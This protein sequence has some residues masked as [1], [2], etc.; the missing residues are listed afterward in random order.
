MNT[1]SIFATGVDAGSTYTR[2]V[3]SLLEDQRLR[4][5]GYGSVPSEGWSKSRIADQQAVS[6]CVLAAVEEAEAMAQTAI[7]TVVAGIGGLTAR[8]ANSRGR[9]DFGRPREIEQRDINRAMDRAMHIHLQEDRMVLQLL[10][11]DFVVD[12]HPGFHDPAE[13][14]GVGDRS[15]RASGYHLGPG[16]RQPDWRDQSALISPST[17]RSMRPSPAAMPPSCR[18]TGAR[19]WPWSISARIRRRWSVTTVNPR[20]LPLRCESAAIIS[21]AIWRTRSAFRSNRRK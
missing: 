5:V 8:G 12:D 2:C 16:A 3:I 14:D 15:Q 6:D 10:P 17:R 1:K 18:R 7:E 9:V 19:A 4:L 13:N 11:Q 20:S 21:R